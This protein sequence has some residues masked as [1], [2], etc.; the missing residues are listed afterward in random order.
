M[1][2]KNRFL[3]YREYALNKLSNTDID[4]VV[5]GHTHV[6]ELSSIK[7][8]KGGNKYYMNTGFFR[9]N[10]TYGVIDRDSVYIG[11]FDDKVLLS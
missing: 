9:N 2:S 6:A 10:G 4:L 8:K 3:S 7:N 5:M 11:V 1:F